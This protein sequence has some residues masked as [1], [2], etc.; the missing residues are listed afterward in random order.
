VFDFYPNYGYICFELTV[1]T[2]SLE[3]SYT[4]NEIVKNMDMTDSGVKD[5]LDRYERITG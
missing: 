5:M 4:Y 2:T 3:H 1:P